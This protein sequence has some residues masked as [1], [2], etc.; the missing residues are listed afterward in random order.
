MMIKE[1]HTNQADGILKNRR[2]NI[3]MI[4][5]HIYMIQHTH[6]PSRANEQRRGLKEE[7]RDDT[8]WDCCTPW[9]EGVGS[10]GWNNK[11]QNRLDWKNIF[12]KSDS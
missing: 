9:V 7:E 5:I 2:V 4:Y 1:T 10:S 12:G 11:R 6:K 3:Y 8:F